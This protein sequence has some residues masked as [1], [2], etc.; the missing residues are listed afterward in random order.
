MSERKRRVWVILELL[1]GRR[2]KV[3]GELQ[4]TSEELDSGEVPVVSEERGSQKRCP[5]GWSRYF[6]VL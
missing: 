6:P 5:Q 3:R 1:M 2:W 4:V